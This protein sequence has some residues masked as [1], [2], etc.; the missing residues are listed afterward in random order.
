MLEG[1]RSFTI[2]C[3]VLRAEVNFSS[4]SGI[5]NP[6]KIIYGR[7]FD[8]INDIYV[9]YPFKPY[10]VAVKAKSVLQENRGKGGFDLVWTPTKITLIS[11]TSSMP[12]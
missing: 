2:Y 10:V 7:Y 4:G 8:L 3:E 6:P 5:A 1:Q 11:T 12:K 9:N